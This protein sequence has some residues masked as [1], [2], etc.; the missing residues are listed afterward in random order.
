M[1]LFDNGDGFGPFTGFLFGRALEVSLKNQEKKE[2]K[3]L[4]KQ[5]ALNELLSPK[6][7][8]DHS[9]R[10]R[11]EDGSRYGLDPD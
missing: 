10:A 5:A 9:W 8:E 2:L 4:Q 6:D 3:R 1:G 11:C 7:T